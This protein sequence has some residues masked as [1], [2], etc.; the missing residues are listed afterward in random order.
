VGG[1]QPIP[2]QVGNSEAVSNEISVEAKL[3]W[4][5]IGMKLSGID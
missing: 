2:P 3:N 1:I 4:T 5:P